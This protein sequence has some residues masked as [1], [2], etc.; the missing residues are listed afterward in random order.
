MPP[1]HGSCCGERTVREWGK[2]IWSGG[3][4]DPVKVFKETGVIN[5][6][7]RGAWG[8]CEKDRGNFRGGG[9]LLGKGPDP[10]MKD[11]EQ[12]DTRFTCLQ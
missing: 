9:H 6:H 12:I 1:E 3:F 2:A 11:E 5:C 4:K 8:L 7:L 10:T